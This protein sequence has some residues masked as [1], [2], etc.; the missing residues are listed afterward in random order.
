MN[1]HIKQRNILA[2]QRAIWCGAKTS[3]ADCFPDILPNDI[4]QML[5]GSGLIYA[6]GDSR[7]KASGISWYQTISVWRSKKHNM[8][9]QQTIQRTTKKN[10]RNH[11]S[12]KWKLRE[13]TNKITCFGI[14]KRHLQPHRCPACLLGSYRMPKN[15]N[16][17]A[18]LFGLVKL[19][20]SSFFRII[21]FFSFYTSLD[22]WT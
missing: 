14:Y 16:N 15:G 18:C 6:F 2:T 17:V 9:F 7:I 3:P 19:V 21:F 22:Q 20:E 8:F 13:A 1:G 10:M 11:T 4:I 5:H 12:K